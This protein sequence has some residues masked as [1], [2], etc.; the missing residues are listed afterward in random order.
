[1]LSLMVISKRKETQTAYTYTGG[2]LSILMNFIF[3]C[4]WAEDVLH[5][6]TPTSPQ[7]PEQENLACVG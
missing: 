3:V 7:P 5:S 6:P 1:M 4:F 2:S